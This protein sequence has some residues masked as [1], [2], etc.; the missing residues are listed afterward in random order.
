MKKTLVLGASL[1]PERYSYLAINRL[2]NH[3]HEVEAIGLKKGEVAGVEI[4]VE[5][6]DFKNIDTI[7]LY[8]NPK[9]Q[10]E[11]YDYILS[12]SP[13]RV[14]FNPGTE[15]PELYKI[16]EKNNIEYEVACTLVLLGTNQY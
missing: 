16:L 3:G 7:T 13:K 15:N 4:S 9:R 2:V 12:L 1:N 14:I 8:L 6:E 11:Y 5:K 10:G